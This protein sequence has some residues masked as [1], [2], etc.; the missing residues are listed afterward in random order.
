[1]T[2]P[3]PASAPAVPVWD[4]PVRLLHW[5]L[6]ASVALAWLSTLESLASIGPWHR[7]VGYAALAIVAL[8]IVWGFGPSRY[9]R[10][11]QFVRSPRVVW[12]YA[13]ALRAHREPRYVGHN[14]LG[15]WMVLALIACVIGLALTGWLYTTDRFWGDETVENAHEF[16]AW[17]LLALAAMHVA[18]VVFTSRRQRENLVLA[19]L[20]GKKA[21][22]TEDDVP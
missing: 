22:P 12:R 21:P 15:A 13:R 8:R 11:A 3:P 10:F 1:M 20:T 16:L 7:P 17:M 2:K 19:M 14:P 18:G 6:V 4:R 5:A 9:A